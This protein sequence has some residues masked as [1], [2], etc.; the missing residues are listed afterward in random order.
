MIA[1]WPPCPEPERILPRRRRAT[2]GGIRAISD[3]DEFTRRNAAPCI[4]HL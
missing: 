4:N 2:L 3:A 1:G